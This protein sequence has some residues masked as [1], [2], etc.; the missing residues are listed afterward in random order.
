MRFVQ[1]LA[2]LKQED[3]TIGGH[4]EFNVQ[5][6]VAEERFDFA[7]GQKKLPQIAVVDQV[8]K[9]LINDDGARIAAVAAGYGVGAAG[10]IEIYD[11]IGRAALVV[12]GK[13]NAGETYR[14]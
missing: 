9:I 1:K 6:L 4:R 13:E 14:R 8:E 2:D 5:S 12:G 11:V 7:C 3:P 10:F